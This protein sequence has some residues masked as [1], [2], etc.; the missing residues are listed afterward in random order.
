MNTIELIKQAKQHHRAADASRREKCFLEWCER[1]VAA[2]RSVGID[3]ERDPDL[4]VFTPYF[5]DLWAHENRGFGVRALPFV[6]VLAEMRCQDS[7]E[8]SALREAVRKLASPYPRLDTFDQFELL[9]E[10]WWPRVAELS[11]QF[12]RQYGSAAMNSCRLPSR[13]DWAKW[14]MAQPVAKQSEPHAKSESP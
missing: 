10:S 8:D 12:N 3:K 9:P 5:D 1:V 2:L 14:R 7:V 13:E 11:Q 6:L 4:V